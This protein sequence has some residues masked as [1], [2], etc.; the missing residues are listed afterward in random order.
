MLPVRVAYGGGFGQLTGAA[1]LKNVL[2]GRGDHHRE[3]GLGDRAGI[4]QRGRVAEG[5]SDREISINRHPG[6]K[7]PGFS[8]TK[9]KKL[10]WE[11]QGEG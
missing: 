1:S 10:K 3:L 2:G 5:I 4:S 9:C 11:K 7:L 6:V 8:V